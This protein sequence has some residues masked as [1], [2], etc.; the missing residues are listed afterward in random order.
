MRTLSGKEK[1]SLA[2]RFPELG[3]D[4][5]SNLQ[6]DG[7]AYYLDR[8]LILIADGEDLIP[9]LKSKAVDR[10]RY[11]EVVV[12]MPAVPF[13]VKGADL[14]RPGIVSHEAFAVGDIVRVTDERNRVVLAFMR[15]LV[16]SS[17][18]ET[19]EKGK[20]A[21]SLHYVGDRWWKGE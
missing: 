16:D 18:L 2:E 20:I 13:M 3:L 1:R 14:L 21:K 10:S 17:A 5:R 9:S 4:K 19:M 6:Y 7:S 11:P 15:A 12:D 8:E